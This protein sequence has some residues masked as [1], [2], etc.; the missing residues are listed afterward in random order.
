LLV[1]PTCRDR[2][3]VAV[4]AQEEEEEEE[5]GIKLKM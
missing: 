1:G 4:H 5:E 3:R 2:F